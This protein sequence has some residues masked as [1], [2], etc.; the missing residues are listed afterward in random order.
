MT[1]LPRSSADVDRSRRD[2]SASQSADWAR[3]ARAGCRHQIGRSLRPGLTA[4]SVKIER[5]PANP[6]LRAG[7]NMP[8]AKL[9]APPAA[10]GVAAGAALAAVVR[11]ARALPALRARLVLASF[12]LHEPRAA[13]QS[14]DRIPPSTTLEQHAAAWL[15]PHR[16]NRK[17]AG[18]LGEGC[19]APMPAAIRPAAAER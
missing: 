9:I 15:C 6:A 2:E 8:T 5:S 19:H 1:A 13:R 11:L 4:I 14:G 17:Y 18:R 3:T 7:R 10:E 12:S 16:A